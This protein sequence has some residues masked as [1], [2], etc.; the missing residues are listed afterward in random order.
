[1]T[2]TIFADRRIARTIPK[3]PSSETTLSPIRIIS[4]SLP[5]PN[6]GGVTLSFDE[7]LK[8]AEVIASVY[9]ALAVLLNVNRNEPLRAAALFHGNIEISFICFVHSYLLIDIPCDSHAP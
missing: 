7:S 8:G 4:I 6:V 3:S 2:R 9:N 1:M 5:E